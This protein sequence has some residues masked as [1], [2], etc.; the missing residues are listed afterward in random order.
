MRRWLTA[1]VGSRDVSRVLYGAIIGQALV[2]ALQV[3]PPGAGQMVVLLVGTAVAVGL[4]ELYSEVIG[5]EA[6][7][8]V[9]LTRARVGQLGADT[10]PVVFGAGF[11]AVYFLLAVVGVMET[12]T[13]FDLSKWSGLGLIC[14]YALIAARLAGARWPRALLQAAAVGAIGIALIV[15]KALLH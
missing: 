3:H 13:A 1:H 11:P 6:R 7:T 12:D 5:E 2:I 8:R 4:A 15:L 10:L 14:G 9:P